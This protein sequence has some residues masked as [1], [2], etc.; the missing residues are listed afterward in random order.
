MYALFAA[1]DCLDYDLKLQVTLDERQINNYIG[2]YGAD[3]SDKGCQR[4]NFLNRGMVICEYK[5]LARGPNFGI[6]ISGGY[7][8]IAYSFVWEVSE[9]NVPT[10]DWW[11]FNSLNF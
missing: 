11:S 2:H 5:I 6:L 4:A 7:S 8:P 1:H 3:L 9:V 10:F